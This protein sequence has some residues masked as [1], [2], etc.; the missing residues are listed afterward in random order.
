[1]TRIRRESFATGTPVINADEL[2]AWYEGY[3]IS[4]ER[5][6]AAAR[7][8]AEKTLNLKQAGIAAKKIFEKILNNKPTKRKVFLDIGGHLG[9]SVRRFY[10]EVEDARHYEIYTFEPHPDCCKKLTQTLAKMKNVDVIKAAVVG[11]NSQE[12]FLYPGSINQADGSSI[13]KGKK[14]GGLDYDN[15]LQIK[16]IGLVAF[17]DS[18][19]I[20][21]KDYVVLKMNIEGA[22]YEIMDFLI[23]TDTLK[24]INQVYVQTHKNKIDDFTHISCSR[25]EIEF[26]AKAERDRVGLFMAEK[27]MAKFQCEGVS[28]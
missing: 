18:I 27:G 23:K 12:R 24:Y 11:D 15:P 20:N 9:E 25:T 3:K 28:L 26:K 8:I 1:M 19:D 7:R 5:M 17:L 2:D 6:S 21:R 14:T 4:P 10:R 16:T 13:L 22:E